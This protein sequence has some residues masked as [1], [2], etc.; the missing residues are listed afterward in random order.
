MAIRPEDFIKRL[1]AISE[2]DGVPYGR[3]HLLFDEEEKHGQAVLQYKG[4]L[5]LSDAFKCFFLE[6][7]EGVNVECRPKIKAPLSEFYALFVP[8]LSHGFQSLCGAERVAIRG[9]PYHGYTLIRNVFDNIVLTSAALQK[10]VDFYSIEGVEPGKPVDPDAVRKLRKSTEFAARRKMTG[11]QSGLSQQ[12][13]AELT[14]WDALFDYETHG[15]RLSLTQAMG[16]MKKTAPLPVLPKFDESAFAMFM[17]RFC[18]VGWMVHRLVPAVQPPGIPLSNGWKE[19]W[20]VI[21]E[22]FEISVESLTKQLGKNI[23]AAI[24]EFV[25]AKFP[26]NEQSSF[27]I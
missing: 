19:K 2:H 10:F 13:L 23:G 16:W 3:A 27:P 25:K 18:E 21:D 6:T 14:K 4:Y 11:D 17:N 24:V 15:A 9:Y 1:D 8:R 20:R 22:S 26:F 5:A 12:T 7:V